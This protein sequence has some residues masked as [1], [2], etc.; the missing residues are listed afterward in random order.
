MANLESW[1]ALSMV[2]EIG[3]VTFKK[4]LSMYNTPDEV[5]KAPLKELSCAEGV[6]EK[7]AHHIKNFS[8]W[9]DVEKQLEL[10]VQHNARLVTYHSQEYPPM[11]RQIE[12]APVN[13]YIRGAIKNED[14]FAIA[15]VGSRKAT[16]YGKA[17]AER[18][19]ST[20]AESGFTIVSGMARGIDT[21]AH[22]GSLSSGGRTIAVLGSG[23]DKFYPPENRGLMERITSSG[24]VVSEFSFG[25]L[26]N[27]ENFPRRNRVIS[28]L[29][30]GVIVVEAA[31]DSG[32]LI[33]AS[34]ALEQN[35]EVFAVP[36]NVTSPNSSGTN[37]LIKKGAKL[38]Q[39]ADDVIE[40][41]APMLKGFVRA[42]K[43]KRIQGT[44]LPRTP[45]WLTDEDRK[46][47]DMLTGEPTHI[48]VL[49][50][51]LSLSPAQT[52]SLLLNLELK[53]I[54]KQAEGKRFYLAY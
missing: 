6:G 37:E 29:S 50:R 26:P 27:R 19:S 18:L 47:C 40:E 28:G 33:T 31:S 36:G 39:N 32:A 25:T 51:G 4:L 14:R 7:R 38:I 45:V 17:M 16:P 8:R 43:I 3:N 23:L 1:I 20:L 15:L 11:L 49:S 12:D 22:T 13:L 52:L 9:K 21:I 2:P 44:E 10:L 46:V 42:D 41:L 35:R 5:F 30:F 48:D 24:Y 54:V 53:G 34:S